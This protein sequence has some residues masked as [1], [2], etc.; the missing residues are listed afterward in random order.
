MATKDI[1]G[2]SVASAGD[3]FA[4]SGTRGNDIFQFDTPLV[5]GAFTT[6]TDFAAG[7]DAVATLTPGLAVSANDFTII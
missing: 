3:G 5:A 1:S 7:A 6:I 4:L 2:G